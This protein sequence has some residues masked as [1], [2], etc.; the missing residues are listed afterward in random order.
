P[1]QLGTMDHE[2]IIREEAHYFSNLKLLS[3]ST[4]KRAID[5]F[6]LV[7]ERLKR[8]Y[9]SEYKAIFLDQVEQMVH[10]KWTENKGTKQE[11]YYERLLFYTHQELNTLPALARQ[12]HSSSSERVRDQIFVS[13]S[14]K[15]K[16]YV[17]EIKKHFKPF[18]QQLK[19]WDHDQIL[20]G[21]NWKEEIQSAIDQTKVIILLLS[22][23]FL[24]SDFIASN[25][26]PAL[27]Q[28]AEKDGAVVLYVILKPCLFE[29]VDELQQYQSMNPANIP[30]LK[31]D[32]IEKE[33]LYVN[34]VRQAKRILAE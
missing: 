1:R 11:K 9:P 2:R 20:P 22:A 19:F 13:Y 10:E 5:Q 3:A 29:V 34:L 14:P 23:D 18:E 30:L 12:K 4:E 32:A 27:L 8:F 6:E 28:A 7:K 26:L 15:D 31:M 25:E 16:Q 17:A 21:Q 33:E 24:A